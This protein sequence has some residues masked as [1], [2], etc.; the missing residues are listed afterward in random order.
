MSKTEN[1]IHFIY[2]RTISIFIPEWVTQSIYLHIYKFTGSILH[3]RQKFRSLNALDLE[4][5]V[6]IQTHQSV[7]FYITLVGAFFF[8]FCTLEFVLKD[9][10]FQEILE[11]L[12]SVTNQFVR[13]CVLPFIYFEECL[14]VWIF[15]FFF[16]LFFC[17]MGALWNTKCPWVTCSS[18]PWCC[19]GLISDFSENPKGFS[20]LIKTAAT[21]SS[22]YVSERYNEEFEGLF[23]AYGHA[24]SSIAQNYWWHR[25]LICSYLL[26]S[27]EGQEQ[28]FPGSFR[29]HKGKIQ[30]APTCG[31]SVPGRP[32]FYFFS[33][34]NHT[35]SQWGH[36]TVSKSIYDK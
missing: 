9:L 17:Y 27:E 20:D 15:S 12:T 23:C 6:F 24:A 8:S 32:L 13:V 1:Y 16:F 29:Q 21:T 19:T 36:S 31:S 5:L 34:R 30:W 14:V 3:S 35:H 33:C 18:V 2:I 4:V 7:R 11:G 26:P 28:T 10:F 25:A 22:N